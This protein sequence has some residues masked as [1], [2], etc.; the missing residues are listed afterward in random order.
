MRCSRVAV[1]PAGMEA[2]IGGCHRWR[3]R[4]G[5]LAAGG[6]PHGGQAGAAAWAGLPFACCAAGGCP[7]SPGTTSG[8]TGACQRRLQSLAK[9]LRIGRAGTGP[10][11]AVICR[12]QRRRGVGAIRRACSRPA[13]GR[14]TVGEAAE[15]GLRVASWGCGSASECWRM[16]E[17]HEAS[18]RYIFRSRVASAGAGKACMLSMVGGG[19]SG[20]EDWG[21]W[22]EHSTVAC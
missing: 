1:R 20:A 2:E 8:T 10:L 6:A 3:P 19:P 21:S 17:A 14:G 12:A 5:A 7:N 16:A 4:G 11:A 18:P 9:P 22:S 13:N 15:A